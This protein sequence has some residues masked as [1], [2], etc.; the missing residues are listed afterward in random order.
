MH[1]LFEKEKGSI[2]FYPFY[3]PLFEQDINKNRYS[4]EKKIFRFVL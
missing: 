3:S 4:S 1:L 2:D